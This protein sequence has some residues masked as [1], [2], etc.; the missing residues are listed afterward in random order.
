MKPENVHEYTTTKATRRTNAPSEKK[1]YEIFPQESFRKNPWDRPHDPTPCVSKHSTHL[2]WC[3]SR[4]S[5]GELRRPHGE[6]GR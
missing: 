5:H 6:T 3:V 2:K 1:G 4:R